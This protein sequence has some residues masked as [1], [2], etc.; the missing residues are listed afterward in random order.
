MRRPLH[1]L[2]LT[3]A[4]AAGGCSILPGWLGG[5]ISISSMSINYTPGVD[6][7]GGI[8]ALDVDLV[9]F[10]DPQQ[11][12]LVSKMTSADWFRTMHRD[13]QKGGA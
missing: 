5:G 11:A 3:L 1:F 13:A 12:A 6:P 4:L 8:S 9:M 7:N 2:I 10:T